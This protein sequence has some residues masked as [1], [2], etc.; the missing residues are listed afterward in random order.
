MKTFVIVAGLVTLSFAACQ[1]QSS[2]AIFQITTS[3]ISNITQS[4]VTSGVESHIE[5]KYWGLCC[6]TKPNPTI[7][8]IISID[9]IFRHNPYIITISGLHGNTKYYLRAFVHNSTGVYYGNQLSFTTL[10]ASIPVLNTADPTNITS[11]TITT[12]GRILTTGGSDI[13][14]CG[15]CWSTSNS[16]DINDDRL[17]NI[18]D[19]G[20]F[21]CP[22]TGLTPERAYYLRTYATNELG[23]GYGNEISFK[24]T[25]ALS[26]VQDI[27]GNVYN[28]ITIGDKTWMQQNLKTTRYSNGDLIGTTTPASKDILNEISPSYQWAY[29]GEE[30]YVPLYGRLYTWYVASDERNLCP[31]GWHIATHE[32]WLSLFDYLI[33]NG[34]GSEGDLAKSIAS[35]TGWISSNTPG[36]PGMDLSANNS[37]GFSGIPAGARAGRDSFQFAGSGSYWWSYTDTGELA[38]DGCYIWHGYGRIYYGERAKYQGLSVRCVKDN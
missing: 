23:T 3:E 18:V 21:I 1:K 19:T 20:N 5:L 25:S 15:V 4:T 8:D 24:T 26:S 2:N 28:S 30:K 35:N 9:S 14:D 13:T 17:T 29:Q 31:T 38:W 37:S 11:V 7:D 33:K 16:P 34:Y 32:E 10:P 12:G 6:N 36:T 27:D 22:V